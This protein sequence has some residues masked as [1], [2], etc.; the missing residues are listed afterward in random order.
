MP[1]PRFSF[2][3]PLDR[4]AFRFVD[5]VLATFALARSFSSS[6]V[7]SGPLFRGQLGESVCQRNFQVSSLGFGSLWGAREQQAT[8]LFR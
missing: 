6:P 1:R 8:S 5:R 7:R 4:S 2:S 3:F